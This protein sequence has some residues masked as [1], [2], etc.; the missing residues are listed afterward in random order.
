M[1]QG[2][3]GTLVIPEAYCGN[4]KHLGRLML[5]TPGLVGRHTAQ[6]A[7]RV[8]VSPELVAIIL[9]MLLVLD[10]HFHRS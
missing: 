4:V 1:H 8:H 7:R 3:L 5:E 9:A 2:S 6:T 10:Y